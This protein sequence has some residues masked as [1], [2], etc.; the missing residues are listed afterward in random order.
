MIRLALLAA[1]ALLCLAAPAEAG[2]RINRSMD[3]VKLGMSR[4][5]VR[6]LKGS[7]ADRDVGPDFVTWRFVRPRME[8]VFEP[9]VIT[10]F[11]SSRAI[12]GPEDIGVGT[13]ERR[14]KAVIDRPVRCSSAEGDR[15]C[16]V[17]S[18]DDGRRN[19]VF[20]MTGGRVDSITIG[21]STP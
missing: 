1:I 9:R 4:A 15:F 2:F 10:L 7:P 5:E 19:T 17:G 14:L 20:G 21:I 8:V 16:V 18:F 12:R 11:T 3:G 13:R 6:D